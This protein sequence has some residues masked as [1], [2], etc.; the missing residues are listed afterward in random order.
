[1]SHEAV[2]VVSV[3]LTE[4]RATVTRRGTVSVEPG[5]QTVVVSG[6]S[7][8]LVEDSLRVSVAG[9]ELSRT[10]VRRQWHAPSI[11]DASGLHDLLDDLE[12][13]VWATTG[14]V[15][16]DAART[17]AAS[18]RL[19]TL[20]RALGRT[21]LSGRVDPEQAGFGLARA[22]EQVVD[23][24]DRLGR[25]LDAARA[26]RRELSQLGGDTHADRGA[27]HLRCDLLLHLDVVEAGEVT[28]E[29]G[30][31]VPSAL[32][33]PSYEAV[34]EVGA[35]GQPE[36]VLRLVATAWQRTEEAWTDIEVVLSTARPSTSATLPPLHHDRLEAREKSRSEA[37]TIDASFRDQVIQSASLTSDGDSA[38][39]GVDD[40][41]ET[42]VFRPSGR[43]TLPSDGRPHRMVVAEMRSPATVR[44]RAVPTLEAAAVLSASAQNTL[45]VPGAGPVPLMAG[46]VLLTRDDGTCVGMGRLPFVAPGERFELGFGSEDDLVVRHHHGRQ[47]EGRFARADRVWFTSTTT[48]QSVSGERLELEVVDRVPVSDLPEV[49]IHVAPAA[50]EGPRRS[51][52]DA[53]GHVRWTVSLEPGAT[54]A[55]EVA[56]AIEKPDRVHLPDPW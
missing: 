30:Y 31:L 52:P 36:L 32:W 40:G 42:R 8:L 54:L 10:E 51:G 39:P 37:R 46:P 14:Q 35:D 25:T 23:R 20:T 44:R 27:P 47:A 28:L 24:A 21:A 19:H 1:M 2:A 5:A 53:R 22:A 12:A 13:R 6:V 48:L 55:L 49:T 43:V 17:H 11:H 16:R 34:L 56:F 41:G 9:A 18:T 45:R 7:P 4:D 38:L 15:E 33:R 3:T 50:E 26:L 29:V